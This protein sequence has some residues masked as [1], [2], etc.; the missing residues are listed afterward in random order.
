MPLCRVQQVQ[1]GGRSQGETGGEI[2]Y[3]GCQTREGR[4]LPCCT[5]VTEAWLRRSIIFFYET[6]ALVL[7]TEDGC[8]VD[9][10]QTP[11]MRE[12]SVLAGGVG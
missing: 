10:V 6:S 12:Q 8:N 1:K 9:K 2:K 5:G 11:S 7:E 4:D 3:L